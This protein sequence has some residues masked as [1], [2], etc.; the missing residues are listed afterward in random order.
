MN[1]VPC[2]I[3]HLSP[4]ELTAKSGSFILLFL[5]VTYRE[6]C[7]FIVNA[8][9]SVFKSTLLCGQLQV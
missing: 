8:A 2:Q 6:L 9:C 5:W 4:H 1:C 3:A 7:C